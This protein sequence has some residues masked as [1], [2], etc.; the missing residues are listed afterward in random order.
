MAAAVTLPPMACRIELLVRQ[1]GA[2]CIQ[3]AGSC[4][5]CSC[6]PLWHLCYLPVSNL[7]I[8]SSTRFHS[9]WSNALTTVGPSPSHKCASTSFPRELHT[10]MR[11]W[12]W[13]W[14]MYIAIRFACREETRKRK[15][16]VSTFK[17]SQK[18]NP[19]VPRI[20]RK[21]ASKLLLLWL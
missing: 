15:T 2:L 5:T 12:P 13:H 6:F 14:I 21:G 17:R 3:R 9:P 11:L 10:I 20:W 7:S 4:Q 19:T 1:D 8:S 18:D 16:T